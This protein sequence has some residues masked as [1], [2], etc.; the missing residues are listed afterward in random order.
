MQ[1]IIPD[2]SEMMRHESMLYDVTNVADQLKEQ[3]GL[4]DDN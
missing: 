4:L 1:Q 2:G 3:V